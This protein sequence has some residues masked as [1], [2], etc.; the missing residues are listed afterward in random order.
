MMLL[1][2]SLSL[3]TSLL[4]I[5]TFMFALFQTEKEVKKAVA[6]KKEEE[7]KKVA[8]APAASFDLVLYIVPW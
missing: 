8:V 4:V 5:S 2:S 6:G 7:P 1:V 3:L